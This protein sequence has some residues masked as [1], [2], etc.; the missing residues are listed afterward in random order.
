MRGEEKE[1]EKEEKEGAREEAG[2]TQIGKRKREIKQI[3]PRERDSL[4]DL[5]H[6]SREEE[7]EEEKEEGQRGGGA[8]AQLR[9]GEGGR[10]EGG[11]GEGG[12]GG[13]RRRGS[14]APLRCRSTSS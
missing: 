5:Y 6:F 8:R 7:E 4:K 3:Y 1:K 9:R 11:G 12:G 2:I 14:S 13:E 10:G